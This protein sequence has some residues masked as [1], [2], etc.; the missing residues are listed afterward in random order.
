[1]GGVS[2]C[3][4]MWYNYWFDVNR[5]RCCSSSAECQ[6]LPPDKCNALEYGHLVPLVS[7]IDC[8][9]QFALWRCKYVT[10]EDVKVPIENLIGEENQGFKYIMYNFNHERFGVIIQATRLARVCVEEAF[11]YAHKRKTFG[12]RLVDHPVI[13]LKLA[14]MVR[15]VESTQVSVICCRIAVLIL[16]NRPGLRA[17]DSNLRLWATL[18]PLRSSEDPWLCWRPKLPPL[19][20]S[21]Q[22][23]LNKRIIFCLT[24]I[25]RE[26]S[27]I[28]GGLAYTRGGQGEKVERIYREVRAYAIPAG[29][30]EIMV[31]FHLIFLLVTHSYTA[32]SR[33]SPSN[34]D[35][36]TVIVTNIIP[37]IIIKVVYL[38]TSYGAVGTQT[39]NCNN[40]I[41]W[42]LLNAGVINKCHWYITGQH[43]ADQYHCYPWALEWWWALTGLWLQCLP[44]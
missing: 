22:G 8:G 33:H 19:S 21:V 41:V 24:F 11:K 42:A 16:W 29:S 34:E 23:T 14:H 39:H 40:T 27:Q 13:R 2:Y 25:Y 10:F 37:P 35:G 15:Q 38:C 4:D 31:S 6:E 12:K 9:L 7:I 32:G 44:M 3:Y 18:R 36:Q 17:W 43:L 26:A 28:F 30:E 20:N 5:Y 1:M